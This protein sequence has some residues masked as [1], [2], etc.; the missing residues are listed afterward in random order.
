[1]FER[2]D[3]KQFE[4][5]LDVLIL[6]K[7]T[8]PKKTVYI[9]EISLKEAFAFMQTHGKDLAGQMGMIKEDEKD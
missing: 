5:V 4:H 8:C 7:Q 9:N 1:M 2:F 3:Q 6:Y